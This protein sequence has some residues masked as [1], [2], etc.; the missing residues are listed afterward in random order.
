MPQKDI[1]EEALAIVRGGGAKGVT[2]RL[3]GG[4]AI[5]AQSP[6]T[7]TPPFLRAYKD[8]DLAGPSGQSA[9]I[10]THMTELGYQADRTFNNLHGRERLFFWDEVHARQV[11]VFLD[12]MTLCHVIEFKDRLAQETV[13]IPLAELLLSKLQI[14]EINDKDLSDALLLLRDHSFGE[15]PGQISSTR[16]AKLLGDDWGLWRTTTGNLKNL[17]SFAET[18]N[19]GPALLRRSQ[20]LEEAI[21]TAPKSLKWKMRARVGERVRWYELPEEEAHN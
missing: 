1:L 3:L 20:E 7:P 4:L 17:R 8:I 10:Q 14:V 11:D 19:L 13:T 6:G 21:E 12:K 16:I 2:L 18:H 9:A 15:E 5:R